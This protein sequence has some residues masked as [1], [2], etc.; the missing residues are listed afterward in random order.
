MLGLQSYALTLPKKFGLGFVILN[1]V[2]DYKALTLHSFGR[3]L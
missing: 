3:A 1:K 2:K